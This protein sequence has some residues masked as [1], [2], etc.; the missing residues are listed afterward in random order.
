ML[1]HIG[2]VDVEV[3]VGDERVGTLSGLHL[4]GLELLELALAGFFDQALL[5]VSGQLDREDAKVT[6][7]VDF[8]DRVAGGSR[9]LL[10]RG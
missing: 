2:P 4:E 5:D 3:V 1:G 7:L 10:V 9:H 8:D 6:L